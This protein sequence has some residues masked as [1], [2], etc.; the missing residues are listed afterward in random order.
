VDFCHPGRSL[1]LDTNAQ[2]VDTGIISSAARAGSKPLGA[3]DVTLPELAAMSLQKP[4]RAVRNLWLGMVERHC[5]MSAEV[6]A[7]RAKEAHA[8]AAHFQRRAALARSAR[9]G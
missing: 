9:I 7:Q 2:H 6:E 4:A 3:R 5:L 1:L 8:N